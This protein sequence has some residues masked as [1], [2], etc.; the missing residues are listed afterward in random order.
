[1]ARVERSM[2]AIPSLWCRAKGGFDTGEARALNPIAGSVAWGWCMA[3]VV[4]VS[5]RATERST[6]TFH[7]RLA[8]K[9]SIYGPVGAASCYGIVLG[10]AADAGPDIRAWFDNQMVMWRALV[11]APYV[12][13]WAIVLLLAWALA[14]LWTGQKEAEALRA[15]KPSPP[16][17]QERKQ[18]VATRPS[19]VPVPS[20]P[21][22]DAIKSVLAEPEEPAPNIPIDINSL[23]AY[24]RS[25]P[26]VRKLTRQIAE[27]VD[28]PVEK[29][30]LAALG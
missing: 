29:L 25:S 7:W 8:H 10:L 13:F 22:A 16:A 1:M 30:S 11:L 4:P 6:R 19:A 20:G 27:Q 3:I 2:R 14:V 24:L 23:G 12:V 28:Q 9:F 15:S 21:A 18:H 26:R 17:I 5:R